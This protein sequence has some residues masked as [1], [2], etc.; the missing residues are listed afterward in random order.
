MNDP[1]AEINPIRQESEHLRERLAEAHTALAGLAQQF[2][3]VKAGSGT[4]LTAAHKEI[5]LLRAQLQEAEQ[6]RDAEAAAYRNLAIK[7][8]DG[9]AKLRESAKRGSVEAAESRKLAAQLADF[10]AKL[11]DT[12]SRGE[13][14]A[15][16]LRKLTLR[17]AG[18]EAQL[19][20]AEQKAAA[21][22]AKAAGLEAELR[23]AVQKAD[24]GTVEAQRLAAKAAGLEAELR[25]AVQKADAGTAEAQKLAAK[26]ADL[27]AKLREEHKRGDAEAAQAKELA[28]KI[29]DLENRIRNVA[30][31]PP[32]LPALP[33][34]GQVDNRAPLPEEMLPP[35]PSVE[36]AL[37]PGWSKALGFLRQS[38]AAAYAHLRKL[39]ATPMEDGQRNRL[40]AAAGALAQGTDALTALGE[41]LDEAGPVPTPGPLET[42]VAAAL[43]VWEPALRRR[44]INVSRR[45]EGQLT[46]ALFHPEGLRLALY[47]VLRNAYESMPRG[48]SLTVRI[49]KDAEAGSAGVSF[50]D[51]GT[52]FSREALARLPAPFATTKPGHLGLGLSLTRRILDRWGGSLEAANNEKVGATVTLRFALG[53]DEL[54]PMQENAPIA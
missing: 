39:S 4:A 20:Q 35:V 5:Q 37:D 52:G 3:R 6:R 17:T 30:A 19:R 28:A 12:E 47:Q 13:A 46:A 41:F 53:R 44:G 11:K 34:A 1:A 22:A 9:E 25:E 7:A 54:P 49:F 33:T 14:E 29:A 43:A 23:E 51:T 16:Q 8:I 24:A 31:A 2:E 10:E 40:K 38:L 48:G 45:M 21:A 36:P 18:L 32:A 26:A 50:S 27:E 15:A 42:P